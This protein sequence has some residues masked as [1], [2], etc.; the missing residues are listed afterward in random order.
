MVQEGREAF[1]TKYKQNQQAIKN[2]LTE[3][4]SLIERHDQVRDVLCPTVSSVVRLTSYS[5]LVRRWRLLQQ[6]PL[7]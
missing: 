5:F 2:K 3:R 4:P 1:K 7:L 6:G